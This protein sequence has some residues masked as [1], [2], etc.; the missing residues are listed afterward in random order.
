MLVRDMYQ[1]LGRLAVP[2][3]LRARRELRHECWLLGMSH[4]GLKLDAVLAWHWARRCDGS[5]ATG[6]KAGQSGQKGNQCQHLV[7][8]D[9]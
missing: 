2:S 1:R 8:P 5:L 3:G 6:R 4:D 9:R 7:I